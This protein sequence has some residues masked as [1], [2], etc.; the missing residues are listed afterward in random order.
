MTQRAPNKTLSA[1]KKRKGGASSGRIP[2]SSSS[3]QVPATSAREERQTEN[4]RSSS[5][6]THDGGDFPT[7]NTTGPPPG[8]AFA[9]TAATSTVRKFANNST[10][11]RSEFASPSM[12]QVKRLP[13][14]SQTASQ[15]QPAS[16]ASSNTAMRMRSTT[17]HGHKIFNAVQEESGGDFSDGGGRLRDEKG[18]FTLSAGLPQYMAK[19][20][21]WKQLLSIR[22]T[23]IEFNYDLSTLSLEE[24][25]DMKQDLH[26]ITN[27]FQ[28]VA[29]S[30]LNDFERESKSIQSKI[31]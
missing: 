14:R 9:R 2:T 1:A 23:T 8:P 3:S 20:F 27:D 28:D 7:I 29:E 12:S 24:L 11:G 6:T 16:A 5:T 13:I 10:F 15:Q 19:Y 4:L 18:R 30:C 22:M 21:E 17:E 25:K 31:E 26:Q